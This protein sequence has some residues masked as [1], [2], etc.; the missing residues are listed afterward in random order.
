MQVDNT[1]LTA[2]NFVTGDAGVLNATHVAD[3]EAPD[4]LFE[5]APTADA[6]GDNTQTEEEEAGGTPEAEEEGKGG[7][8]T[9]EEKPAPKQQ[10]RLAPE[11]VKELETKYGTDIKDL[12]DHYLD[13][14]GIDLDVATASLTDLQQFRNQQIIDAQ[15]NELRNDWGD[16]FTSNY[17]EVK[18]YFVEKLGANPAFDT[19]E[20]ARMIWARIAQERGQLEPKGRKKSPSVTTTTKKTQPGSKTYKFR[21][22]EIMSMSSEEYNRRADEITQA[23][24]NGQVDRNR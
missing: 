18:K 20:G 12:I 17:N 13:E 9:E 3:L 10:S 7:E 15:L 14:R 22:S 2:D 5:A 19:V 1:I 8:S 4:P 24:M 23:W 11:R 16:D 21:Q 6:E